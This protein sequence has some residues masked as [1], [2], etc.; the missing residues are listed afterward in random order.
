VT[1]GSMASLDE[2][3][4]LGSEAAPRFAEAVKRVIR[5]H[6][7]DAGLADAAAR[8]RMPEPQQ[9]RE[10]A[11]KLRSRYGIQPNGK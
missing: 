3:I 1:D 4:Q 6:Q 7:T 11:A 10:M 2:L 8:L 5:A 9:V